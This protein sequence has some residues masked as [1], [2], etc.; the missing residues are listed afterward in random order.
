VIQSGLSAWLGDKLT[1]VEYFPI[2][3]VLIVVTFLNALLTEVAS[4]A[5]CVNVVIPILL[6]LVSIISILEYPGI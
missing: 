4:N 6:A 2:H 5:A 1:L 3:V